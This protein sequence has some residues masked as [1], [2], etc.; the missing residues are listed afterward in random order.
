MRTSV[1]AETKS[2]YGSSRAVWRGGLLVVLAVSAAC[3]AELVNVTS[4]EIGCPREEIIVR[5][6][7]SGWS[8]RSWVAE[9]RGRTYYCSGSAGTVD[10][11]EQVAEVT[12]SSGAE[13]KSPT[14]GTEQGCNYDTQCKGDRVRNAG[15]CVSPARSEARSGR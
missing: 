4:G 12:P 8:S 15:S 7:R 2:V 10:C 13:L 14:G 9:C 5:D 1:K 11:E 3:A 6:G